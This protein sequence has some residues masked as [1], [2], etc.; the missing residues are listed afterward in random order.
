MSC[1]VSKID[2]E[3]ALKVLNFAIYHQELTEMNER[4]QASDEAREREQG[5]KRKADRNENDGPDRGPK[6][7]RGYVTDYTQE[8]LNI[9]FQAFFRSTYI[10]SLEEHSFIT[11]FST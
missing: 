4:E 11:I 10:I 6:D 9:L 2:V 7:R 5:R 3:A 8:K 1:Q